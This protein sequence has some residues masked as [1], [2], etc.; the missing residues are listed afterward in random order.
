MIMAAAALLAE[1]PDPDVDTIVE[2]I[3]NICRCGTYNRVVAAIRR[4]ASSSSI[5]NHG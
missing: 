5:S 2:Q 4:A 3:T 1:H